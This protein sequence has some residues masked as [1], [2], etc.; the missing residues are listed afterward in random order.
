MPSCSRASRGPSFDN[1]RR[2]GIKSPGYGYRRRDDPDERRCLIA[3]HLVPALGPIR[4]AR[5]MQAFGSARGACEARE[6]KLAA[7]P[8]IGPRLAALIVRWRGAIDVDEELRRANLR[9]GAR[10]DLAGRRLP[11]AAP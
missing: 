11:G 4:I 2:P 3:L 6:K 1:A 9:G 8:G 10:A 7:V 5:L